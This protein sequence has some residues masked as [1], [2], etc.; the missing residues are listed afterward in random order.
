MGSETEGSNANG[1]QIPPGMKK[2][3]HTLREIVN[4]NCSDYEIYSVL[5]DCDMD[6]NDAVQRLLSQDVFHEVKSKRERRKE[7]K[8][9]QESKARGSNNGHRGVKVGA[10]YTVG[11]ASSQISYNDLDKASYMRENPYIASSITS[12]SPLTYRVRTMNEHPS[13]H[14]YD[15]GRNSRKTVGTGGAISSSEQS[16]RGSQAAL[17]RGPSGHVSMADI[18]KMG[19]SDVPGSY[20]AAET[21]Y[22]FQDTDA[23]GSLHCCLKAL[24]N[25]SPSPAPLEIHQD[26]QCPHPANVSKTLHQSGTILN[27]HDFDDELPVIEQQASVSRSSILNS[28]TTSS[29]GMLPNQ[30]HLL[31][32]GIKLSK[33]CQPEVQVSD[34]N[35]SCKIPAVNCVKFDSPSSGQEKINSVGGASLCNDGS[36]RQLGRESCSHLYFANGSAHLNDEVSSTAASL[37]QLSLEKEAKLVLTS[38]DDC[39]VVFP[40]DMRTLGAD[41]SHLSFGTY[42]TGVHAASS[43]PLASNPSKSNMKEASSVIDRNS[44]YFGESLCSEQLELMRQNNHKVNNGH[45]YTSPESVP[46]SCFKNIQGPSSPWSVVINPHARNLPPLHRELQASSTPVPVDLL[47][48]AVQSVRD[49]DWAYSSFPGTL[50]LTSKFIDIVSSAVSPTVPMAEICSGSFSIPKSHSSTLPGVAFGAGHVLP[51]HL[52]AH[53]QSTLSLEELISLSGYSAV[54][55]TYPCTPTALQRAYQD[56]SANISV[57]HDPLAGMKYHL[58]QLEGVS[59]RSSLPLSSANISGYGGLGNPTNL[60]GRFLNDLSTTPNVGLGNPTNFSVNFLNDL[61]TTTNG[62]AAGCNDFLHAQ[63]EEGNNFTMPQKDGPGSRTLSTVPDNGYY[64]SRGQGQLFSTYQQGQQLSQN[65][66]ALGCTN[67]DHYRQRISRDEQQKLG[68]LAFRS[69]Q[70]P[71]TQL[72]PFRQHIY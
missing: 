19:W 2:M 48:S 22:A 12:S 38:E 20:S 43:G 14:S 23:R 39:A 65:Y 17:V 42:N 21:S 31:D 49:S 41:C 16:S 71:S 51:Q 68:D 52:M 36:L 64:N 24:H 47:A 59:P 58:Q 60:C 32:D 30:S 28:S 26:L 8:E 4:N 67:V 54:P 69:S 37:Q 13:F 57:L 34:R 6:P 25:S 63:Y 50:S 66:G 70:G 53:P 27:Q 11:H 7:M 35:V 44:G 56:S 18:I 55:Q 1:S 40:N 45:D 3:V 29:I 33:N 72:H 10:E 15:N 5:C 62:S 46:D 61:S 9:T